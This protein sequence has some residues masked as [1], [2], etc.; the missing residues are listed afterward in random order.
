M[1]LTGPATQPNEDLSPRL[2]AAAKQKVIEDATGAVKQTTDS[3]LDL[4]KPLL[5]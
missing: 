3:V 2:I 5:Q 4:L 1:R